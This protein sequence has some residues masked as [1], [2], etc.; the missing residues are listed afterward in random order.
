MTKLSFLGEVTLSMIHLN[1][2]V[3]HVGISSH[4][5][6]KVDGKY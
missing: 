5:F 6:V 4:I 2:G 3:T 1:V